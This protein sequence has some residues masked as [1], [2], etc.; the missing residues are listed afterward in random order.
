MAHQLNL[1]DSSLDKPDKDV[2]VLQFK[3]VLA[4]QTK[5]QVIHCTSLEN[6][7]LLV[8]FL[9]CKDVCYNLHQLPG[10]LGTRRISFQLVVDFLAEIVVDEIQVEV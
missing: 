4:D 3:L 8:I 9:S 7:K 5:I 2:Q 1:I 6:I 10:C